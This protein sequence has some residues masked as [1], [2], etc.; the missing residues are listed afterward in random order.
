MIELTVQH[1]HNHHA[2]YTERTGLNQT[3]RKVSNTPREDFEWMSGFKPTVEFIQIELLS[4]E[5]DLRLNFWLN[6]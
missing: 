6:W 4:A 5:G 3:L 1:I 2:V